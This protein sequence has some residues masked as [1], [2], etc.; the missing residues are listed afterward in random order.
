[1][2]RRFRS[3]LFVIAAIG[4]FLAAGFGAELYNG[5]VSDL[6]AP[7]Y[8][9][10]RAKM[11]GDIGIP[12][13]ASVSADGYT[14]TADAVIRDDDT[15]AIVYTFTRDDGQPIPEKIAFD[16]YGSGDLRVVRLEETPHQV[17]L[18]KTERHD[19]IPLGRIK[20]TAFSGLYANGAWLADGPWELTFVQRYRN[21]TFRRSK[22]IVVQ[23][24]SGGQYVIRRIVLS[25]L[26]LH[27]DMTAP[28]PSNGRGFMDDFSIF[29]RRTDG[30]MLRVSG[31][32]GGGW[33]DEDETVQ[34]EFDEE[35][36]LPVFLD[37]IAALVICD[38]D[39]PIK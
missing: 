35:F 36:E 7:L 23:G 30:T 13:G 5:A 22:D 29:M 11:D 3:L 27:L 12:L 10:A 25:P 38:T 4:C 34:V 2:K 37:E 28:V 16:Q 21:S 9:S 14:L 20:T 17:K 18:V 8:G 39:V 19:G 33:N 1:M 32:S 15:D 24:E 6:L 26:S 31:D